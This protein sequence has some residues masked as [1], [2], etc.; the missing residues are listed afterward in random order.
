MGNQF[1]HFAA[2]APLIVIAL[3]FFVLR[4]RPAAAKGNALQTFSDTIEF[5]KFCIFVVIP[6]GKQKIYL[7]PVY[8]TRLGK[9]RVISKNSAGVIMN[10]SAGKCLVFPVIRIAPLSFA[11]S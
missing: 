1:Q 3:A 6:D 8:Y 10:G 4:T 9:S 5:S 7:K 2:V 11:V